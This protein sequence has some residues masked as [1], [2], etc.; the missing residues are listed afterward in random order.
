MSDC[1]LLY[2]HCAYAR[3]VPPAV[4]A[5]VLAGLTNAGVAFEAVSDLCQMAARNDPRM[6]ELAEGGAVTIAACYPR[7]VRGLFT[8]NETPLPDEGVT[9][10]NMRTDSAE[11]VL[12][13]ML[14]GNA[15]PAAPPDVLAD[16]PA[17][18]LPL[19]SKTAM[20]SVSVAAAAAGSA[21]AAASDRAGVLARELEQPAAGGW[22]PW[23]PV[24]DYT[25][26]TNCMQCLSFCLFDVYG[27]KDGKIQVQ[28]QDHCKTDCPACSRVCPEVAIMFPKYRHG[29][30]N[31][32]VVSAD[33]I[34][35][36]A[37]KVDISA[38]LGGDIY[39]QLRD[40]SAKAKSRFSKERD[41][42][43]AL[44]ERQNCLIKLKQQMN[45][46]IPAEVIAALPSPDEIRAKAEAA[47]ARAQEAL[48]ANAAR[49]VREVEG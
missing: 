8:Q 4:K 30:I 39:A 31:G 12:K 14:N 13:V 11:D 22:K 26:C 6:K 9:I 24:I 42:D 18:P 19:V 28:N 20:E 34:R 1:R 29:P 21:G 35:R 27:V 25:R 41:E 10:C 40:R 33:D 38:L 7:A 46:D 43:R 16:V 17:V 2:C 45:L 32:D 3:V 36:E 15:V 44:T 23:F 37:M 48:Q 49:A 47:A 5:D